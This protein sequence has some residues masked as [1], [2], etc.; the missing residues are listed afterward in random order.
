MFGVKFCFISVY[1]LLIL[2]KFVDR[3]FIVFFFFLFLTSQCFSQNVK[4]F[5]DVIE[6]YPEVVAAMFSANL[7]NDD[8]ALISQFNNEWGSGSFTNDERTGII[9]ISNAFLEK[10][11][12]NI[13]YWQFWRCLLSFKKPE[14]SG[15]G[16]DVWIKAM[17]ATCQD[18][19]TTPTSLQTLMS[20]TFDLLN[21]RF[22]S[23]S[24]GN[25]WKCSNDDYYFEY[26]NDRLSVVVG[27]C[28]LYCYS[29]GDSIKIAQTSGRY[30]VNEQQW[31]GKGGTVTWE[32]AGYFASDVSAKLS[33]YVI[34]MKKSEYEAD[35]VWLT[36]SRFFPTPV[37]GKLIDKVR[38]NSNPETAIYPE[39]VTYNKKFFFKDIYPY[40]N[41]EG[42]ISLQGA[43]VI[44]AGTDDEKA[45]IRIQSN[46]SIWM[47]V[48]SKNYV[49]RKDR[50]N[51]NNVSLN[52]HLDQ[53]SI[54]HNNLSF[55][56][57][58]E[59]KEVN[60][61]RSD[62]ASSKAPYN[63]SYHKIN[64]DFEQLLWKVEE[65]TMSL[66]TTRGSAGGTAQFRSQ[67]FFDQRY[68]ES[69]QYFDAVHPLVAVK[70][71]ATQY[72]S[73]TFPSEVFAKIIKRSIPEARQ[74]LIE[75]AKLGFIIF[76][77][78]K[79]EATIL[80]QLHEF[81]AAAAKKTDFDVIDLRSR[82]TAPTKNALLE[83][84]G[85]LIINGIAN[86]MVSDSQ[87]VIFTPKNQQVMMKRNRAIDIDGRID[88]GQTE[89]YGDFL[90]FNYDA[91]KIS[92]PKGDSLLFHVTTGEKDQLGRPR[93]RRLITAI[94]KLRGD[95]L[96][97]MPDNKSGRRSEPQFPILY[98]D[99]ASYVYYGASNIAGG[100]YNANDFFFELDP[101]VLENIDRIL[102]DSL[103][104]KG[105]FVSADIF[106]D[107]RQTLRVQPDYSLGFIHETDTAI[108]TYG[109]SKLFA[110]IRLS[111]KGLEASGQ[112][113]YLTA[114][115]QTDQFKLYPDSMNVASAKEFVIK[116]QTVGTEFPDLK[117]E[118]NRI[119]WE[120]KKDKMHIYKKDK[121]F[122]VYNPETQFDGSLLLTPERLTGKGR[123]DID[124]ADVRSNNMI[125]KANSF[126]ADTSN[127]RLRAA[128]N[129][130]VQ[131]ATLDSIRSEINFDTRKGR[132][133]PHVDYTL[134]Q[135][136]T[137][138][139]AA[140]IDGMIW[141][142][143]GGKLNIQSLTEIKEPVD[144]KY[145]YPGESKGARYYSTSKDADS[146]NFVA[147]HAT[148]DI[149]SSVMNA[150]GV[151]LVHTLDAIIFPYEGKLTL[152]PEGM[153]EAIGNARV[154]FNDQLKQ[155]TVYG[156]DIRIRGRKQYSGFGKYDYTDETGKT[157]VVDIPK[158]E[159]DRFG[160]TNANGVILKENDFMLSPFFRYQGNMLL[161][162]DEPFPVFDGAMQIVQEC[163][164]IRP[165]W[166]KFKSAI[167]AE[168][169]MFPVDEAPVNIN[170]NKI[171]NGLFLTNDSARI[172]PA[173]FSGRRNYSDNQL[174]QVSGM[175]T[176]DKDS[177]IY[178]I[179]PEAKLRN[180]DTIGNLL[181]LNRDRCLLSAEGSLSLGVDLGRVKTNV[182]GRIIHNMNNNETLL[183][184]MMS[185]DFLFD[186]NLA[187]MI[188]T[189]MEG[190]QT[191]TGVDMGRTI[192]TRGMNEWL[193]V[194]KA[195]AFRR[196]ALMGRVRNFPEELSKTLVL[197]QVRL[198]LNESTRSYR[199]IGK[200]GVG[201]L[202]GHQVNRL[203]DGMIEIRKKLGGDE[204]DIYLKLD[205]QNWFYF[206][207][208]R[209]MMQVLSSDNAF[210]ERLKK[211]PEKQRKMDGRP[212]FRYMIAA[213][214]KM[215]QFLRV[216]QRN[217]QNEQAPQIPQ[218][219][220]A[221][222]T[223]Q[224][225]QTPPVN[226]DIDDQ[227]D[228]T[229]PV[230]PPPV[231]QDDFVPII[232]IE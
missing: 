75:V 84:K 156:A 221:P 92:F 27:I 174:I 52:I 216:Y 134:V 115:I 38:N 172:Y 18:R 219:P 206:G 25:D 186:N 132:F 232:E 214:G 81:L 175:L 97:D 207:Y 139:F 68:Y 192:Y 29:K 64:M 66:S 88:A 73:E 197:T 56:Y 157:F 63:N 150:E 14:N 26:A 222:Q 155:H 164:A 118:G 30:S 48:K 124:A 37:Q 67:N 76:D 8:K 151:N 50:V 195:E 65:P 60:F 28:D 57:L 80:P 193:G 36:H 110:E 91:F 44:G 213:S 144:F 34:N 51:A 121:N 226:R 211:L 108:N 24:A 96:I 22:I 94:E 212:D 133:I 122:S 138:K 182:V 183:D 104:L 181:S 98:S 180:R 4:R 41:Y 163:P 199:S 126:I 200:I 69:L 149:A 100:A 45:T 40:V 20:A 33:D 170:N 160:K 171:Y 173:F 177:M 152:T 103:E 154:V 101:F 215:E 72:Y 61:T 194:R 19:R 191:L 120:P 77:G 11:A 146:L 145:S 105:K 107:M 42:G 32:R 6:N 198:Y 3:K 10:K 74:Q 55:A 15:K 185:L 49:F 187:G 112:L 201:N 59:Q 189:T 1:V 136:P 167:N 135:L 176:Y 147:T 169:V 116:K 54:Y 111:N 220:Q 161:S 21:K 141:D 106:K 158:I 209:G 205:D 218:I 208:T 130:P 142:M 143:D 58:V 137:N 35:S 39:F 217:A 95:I 184:L 119:H 188:A 99:S 223:P 47:V 225:P 166:L 178:Y 102:R 114:S 13:H 140:Y 31:K 7:S 228:V 153:L 70:Q 46:D 123:M 148:L 43:R 190:M 128:K 196:E 85:D 5:D 53:D 90:H 93:T 78:D 127:F 125:M 204:M 168:N 113:D 23:S 86:F 87:Q 203:V 224:T 17:E 131:L 179:A 79:D 231:K 83:V 117:S 12:R 2:C 227:P 230:T 210:N 159:T 16:F 162:S 165:D 89:L 229:Q 9:R 62:V 109:K 71:C 129:G 82:V 202:F